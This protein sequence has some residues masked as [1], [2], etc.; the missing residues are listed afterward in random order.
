MHISAESFN[1][2]QKL[3][4]LKEKYKKSNYRVLSRHMSKLM[5]SGST[6]SEKINIV[7]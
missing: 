6:K 2:E 5:L 1:Y 4:A 7:Q 3:C